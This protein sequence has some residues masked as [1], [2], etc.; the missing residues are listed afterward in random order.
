MAEKS[1]TERTVKVKFDGEAAGV[2]RAA[3]EAERELKR[4]RTEAEKEQKAFRSQID[5]GVD[6]MIKGFTG[7]ATGILKVGAAAGSAQGLVGVAGTVASLSGTLLALPAV[8]LAGAVGIGTLKLATAGFGDAV[9]AKDQEAWTEAT[10]NMA[11]AAVATA[12]A[13][14]DQRDE[15]TDLRKAVQ[16][17]FFAGFDDDVRSLAETFLP[18]LKTGLG[19]VAAEMNGVGRAGAKALLEPAAVNDVNEVLTGTKDLFHELEPAVGNVLSGILGIGGVG[20]TKLGA[21]GK[22]IT[23]VTADFKAWVDQG[24]ESGK[25]NDLIDDGVESGKKLG[26]VVGNLGSIGHKVF[27]GLEVDGGGFLDG[28]IETT[29]AV[30]DFLDSAAGQEAIKALGET[31]RV[32]SDVARNILTVAL[33]ELAPII[34]ELAPAAQEVATAVGQW[35]VQAIETVGPLLQ[36]TA[37]FLSDNKEVLGE[38]V[39]LLIGAAVAYKGLQV[40]K[41]VKGWVS[42]IPSLFDDVGRTAGSASDKIGDAGT[43]KGL[44]GRLGGLKALG[45]AAAIGGIAV[46]LDEINQSVAESNPEKIGMVEDQLHNLVGAGKEVLSL[47]FGGIFKDISSEWE[48]LTRKFETGESPIGKIVGEYDRFAR[49]VQITP[50]TFATNTDPARQD[51]DQLLKEVNDSAGTININGNDNPA[52]FALRRILDEIKAGHET[53]TIDGQ[54]VPADEALAFVIGRINRGSGTVSMNGNDQPAGAILAGLLSNI[55][56]SGGSVNVSANDSS[57]RGVVNSLVQDINGR[58]VSIFVNAVGDRGGFASAGRLAGGGPV[59]GP[60]S[61][62]SDTAGWFALSNGEHV[63][64]AAEVDAAGGHASVARMRQAVRFGMVA[65]LAGGGPAMPSFLTAGRLPR[66][67]GPR[68]NVAAPQTAVTVMIDGQEFRGM[69]QTQIDDS[70]RQTRRSQ[71]VGSGRGW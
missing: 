15:F 53:V 40:A 58:Q 11:P 45:A 30:E 10:K 47:N 19:D 32:V 8:A 56:N 59:Q 12:A 28:M 63:W 13:I 69:V 20:A 60:G 6:S 31:L 1:T 54:S 26:Q 42:G 5:G 66:Q 2:A 9:N 46:G 48:Q 29:Q 23:G 37:G 71:F 35:L 18:L 51:V 33:R 62:T 21:L 3:R 27:T 4:L 41:E 64:T 25:I 39:P 55:N 43:G 65:G 16:G 36:V 67:A 34:I 68:V 57:A 22:V 50:I 70:N 61:G 52:G 24:V 14:R 44:A 38:L 17:Q 7:V 49:N